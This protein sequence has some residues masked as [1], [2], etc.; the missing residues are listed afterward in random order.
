MFC[1]QCEQTIGGK[2]CTKFGNCG[3]D[4]KVAALQD[5]LI[6]QLK[7]IGFYGQ[8]L[9][10]KGEKIDPEIQKFMMDASFSTLTNVN[11]DPE[12]FIEYLK[13]A[14]KIKEILKFKT[15]GIE[16]NI[17]CAAEYILPDN[18]DEM[19][20][21]ARKAGIMY[22][23]SLDADIR[24]LRQTLIYGMKGM[25]A[26]AHHAH[27]LGKMDETVG[28]FFFK[29]FSAVT[30]DNLTVDELFNLI[31]KFGKV[32]L[33]CMELLD[34]A[35]TEINGN[36]EPTEVV[37]TK[38]K[39][40]FIVVSG[41]DLRDLKELL[42]Q[43]ECKGVNIYTHSEMLPSHG[44]PELKKYKHLIGN[45]GGAWQEQQQE[46]DDI[47]GCILMT[48]N[49][50]QKPRESYKDRIFTTSIVGWPDIAHIEEVNG[51]KDFTTIINKAIELGGWTEDEPEKKIIVGFGHN[52]V[53]S[54]AD[55]IIEAIKAEK[56]KH[57][58]LIGGCDGSRPGRN[59]YT[60]F[61][62]KTPKNTIIL[63]LA[64]G[65]YRFNKLD[66]GKI[67]DFPRLLDLGQ[68][69]DAYSAIKIVLALA[70]AF[71]CDINEL[72]LS[73]ILSWYEQKAVCILLT[74]LSL[75]IRDIYLG[76]TLPAFIS[77]TVLQVLI[78]K[79]NIKPISTPEEDL[80][81]ILGS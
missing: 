28:E 48:T 39:G 1:Y 18:E 47:P 33:K 46:F 34:R 43:T 9:I 38:K 75:G 26:Y 12:R 69:N 21:D 67:G 77:P 54:I 61:A 31:M 16:D 78:D 22:D 35:N 72:P 40:P 23:D 49:C 5:L 3:K 73:M 60:E 65:K 2:G 41:H 15:K 11:F 58:F 24:S 56:I 19:L 70:D 25:G 45:F 14:Q 30:N 8:K 17:P 59:Y 27:V 74:L 81:T 55:Q 63:T 37:I 42:E 68:C 51:K 66:F 79:F 36:P 80:K 10:E 13:E 7:G 62:E 29:G 57:F 4:A 53:I 71:K 64:C 6:Y 52:A 44:Y 76:P 50:L 20:E 32:N